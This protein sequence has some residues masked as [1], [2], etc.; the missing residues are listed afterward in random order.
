MR[1]YYKK[2]IL[3][4]CIQKDS[5]EY[6]GTYEDMQKLTKGEKADPFRPFQQTVE[7]CA[8]VIGLYMSRNSLW[9]SY[10]Q[11]ERD[12]IA[13]FLSGFAHANTVP[14]NWRLFNMLDM[15]FLHMYGYPIDENIMR[16]HA[17]AI[18]D[19]YAGD[20]WYRDGHSFDYY[21]CWAFNMYGPLWNLWYGYENMPELAARF[22]ETQML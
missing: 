11:K 20:G 22:E 10:T 8:L 6:A 1:D 18:L 3:R 15:A 16:G 9:E 7:T 14:Q 12:G 17:E 4:S 5:I 19:Y 2:H 13:G 21:S